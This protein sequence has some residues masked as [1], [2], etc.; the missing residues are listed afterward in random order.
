VAP[1]AHAF[2]RNWQ[3]VRDYVASLG[4]ELT[5]HL[6]DVTVDE[7]LPCQPPADPAGVTESVKP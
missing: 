5:V 7:L 6:G 1:D 2:N 3:G 4:A